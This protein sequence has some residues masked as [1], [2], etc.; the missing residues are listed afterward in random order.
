MPSWGSFSYA[1][2]PIVAIGGIVVLALLLRWAFASGGSVVE[3]P[4]RT[5]R[6]DE[7][8]MLLPVAVPPSYAEGEMLRLRLEDAGVR[9]TLAATSD[10]PRILVW[11]ADEAR[12]RTL[13]AQR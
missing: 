13:L 5:G 7:Y 3:R 1:Y 4:A 2:G 12:A 10:G 11:P 8:G 9:A 6:A